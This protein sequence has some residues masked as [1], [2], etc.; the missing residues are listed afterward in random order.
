MRNWTATTVMLACLALGACSAVGEQA[1]DG[2]YGALVPSTEQFAVVGARDI[3]GGFADLRANGIDRIELSITGDEVTFRLDG[4]DTVKRQVVERLE[5]TDSEG[6][7]PFKG[8]KEVLVLGGE[9]LVIGD[10]QIDKPVIWQ[11]SFD[12]SPVI[13]L[14]PQD[15]DERGP[16]V[17]CR[18]NETCLLLSSGVDPIGRYE[19]MNDPQLDEN[20]VSFIEVSGEFVE[21]T[22]D[23]GEHLQISR[24]GE[25]STN[26]CG[27]SETAVWDV[28]AE[29]GLTM[30]DP[31]LIH[32]LCPSN[33]GG[34]IELIIM[35]RAAIPVLAPL[36]SE[37]G[38]D[39]CLAGPY[40]LWF[41]PI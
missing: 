16:S 8:K 21:F 38:G 20:P 23:T 39:W 6:S 5:L 19:G 7:G 2:A 10:L 40:C 4:T 9:A 26:A 29:M 37:F 15:L 27:L 28:P 32:T 22:L 35:E 18:A 17:S 34:G 31:V 3:P 25:S 14:K 13:T 24:G 33:P 11:G 1:D 41:A 30:D 36:G 12:G